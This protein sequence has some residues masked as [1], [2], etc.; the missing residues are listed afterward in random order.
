MLLGYLGWACRWVTD[1]GFIY[2]RI[3]RQLEAGNGP[4]YNVGQRVEA[5]TS[6]LW[7]GI[8]W[9]T[10][11]VTPLRLEWLAVGLGILFSLLGV[12][13]ALVAS[14]QLAR[15]AEARAFVVPA[16][17][18]VWVGFLPM[19]YFQSAGLET[20]LVFA[21]LGASLWVLT[22]WARA[23]ERRMPAFG[24][25]L[26]GLGWLVRPELAV[27]S[28]LFVLLVTAGQWR[29]HGWG[30]RVR[31]L[32]LAVALPVAF[33]LFRMGYFGS[34]VANTAIAKEGSRPRWDHGWLYLK[35]F[36]KPYHLWL[37]IAALA[38]GAFAPLLV[39]LRRAGERRSQ[40]V[41]GAFAFAAAFNAFYIVMIGG[42]Y[43]HA[44]LLMPALFAA[45]APVAVVPAT[46]RYLAAAVIVAWAVVAGIWLRPPEVFVALFSTETPFVLPTNQAGSITLEQT[47]WSRGGRSWGW[48]Q[49]DGLYFLANPFTVDFH[50]IA[51]QPAPGVRLPTLVL[52]GIGLPGFAAGP[53]FDVF[54]LLGLADAV[55]GHFEL[56]NRGFAGHE[57]SMPGPW[58]AARLA[59]AG[60]YPAASE[61]PSSGLSM[62]PLTTG[63]AFDE[64]VAWARAAWRCPAIL[65][66]EQS[67]K[68][69][70]TAGRFFSNV[71]R[72]F[73]HTRLRI[74]PD[75]EEAYHRLCGPGVPAEVR[76]LRE[77]ATSAPA[78][79]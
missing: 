14:T 2:F 46:R 38:L 61:F 68:A 36:A 20:G 24:A 44:R 67:T 15:R 45:C 19:W 52:Y 63:R 11:L 16:G 75:P 25:V 72:S 28:A 41:I 18:A 42:D 54:D 79:P 53:R 1:D 4:V 64:Q 31:L 12:A 29:Q 56:R 55:G 43:F 50:R 49:G 78:R 27:H 74:P 47:G 69:P 48:F 39:T 37:P 17:L 76:A 58:V 26:I 32:A 22:V 59:A 30:G 70:L 71:R 9:L 5:F 21:W 34:L 57:K 13:F 51:A 77:T 33:Q 23:P 8:L 3:V 40:W 66:L 10:D 60:T 7:L 65:E 62:I 73:A 35:D 6:P